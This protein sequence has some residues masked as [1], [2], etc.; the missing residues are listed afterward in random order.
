MAQTMHMKGPKVNGE[1]KPVNFPTKADLVDGLDEKLEEF[2]ESAVEQNPATG[3]TAG[4]MSAADKQKLDDLQNYTL[5]AASE[6]VMGGVKLYSNTGESTDGTMTQAAIMNAIRAASAS[7]GGND[8]M[9]VV[10]NNIID[11]KIGE[12]N[13]FVV[14]TSSNSEINITSSDTSVATVSKT[15]KVVSVT[16]VSVGSTAITIAV[17]N[18]SATYTAVVDKIKVAIPTVNDRSK[19]YNGNTQSPIIL[20]EPSATIATVTGKTGTNAGQYTLTYTLNN[21]N[22]YEWEDG[23]TS[24]K[25]FSWNIAKATGNLSLSAGAGTVFMSYTKTLEISTP[26]DGVISAVSSDEEIATVSVSDTTVTITGIK[27]GEA[28]I[29]ISQAEGTN[30]YA[31]TNV[32]YSATVKL[33][34]DTTLNNNSWAVISEIS[35]LGTGEDYWDVGDCKEITLNGN[36]GSQLT[37]SD[38]KLCVYI[39]DFNYAMNG[40]AENNIIWGGFK[41]ALTEG[42]DVALA[43]S[44]YGTNPNSGTIAFNMNHS[45]TTNSG[46]G[47]YGTNYGGWKGSDLRYDILGATSTAPSGYNTLKSTGNVGYD[48]TEKTLL[49]PKENTLLAALPADLRSVL[50]LWSRW[51]D[52]VGNSSNADAN[53]K[54]TVDAITLLAEAEVF[55][56]RTYANQYEANHLKQM[57]YYANGNSAIKYSHSDTVSVVYWWG[58]SPLYTNDYSFCSV[59]TSGSASSSN[60]RYSTAL[61]PAFKT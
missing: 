22:Q 13:T 16:G 12:T 26:S 32:D 41:T 14:L 17:G 4:L 51:I 11:V 8:E 21:T 30:H 34:V 48:A 38:E 29:A 25:E 55:S 44:A 49:Q 46:N 19:T 61:A 24:A 60:A 47:Y 27:L 3:E 56:A 18:C 53:I 20:N 7:G 35:K 28:T 33:Y 40:T 15:G 9:F 50:R 1:R 31:P 54:E 2:A 58:S 6:T 43:D 5:P 45:W 23:T 57:A 10:A 37:L 52:A 39:L 42:K 59:N 36:V